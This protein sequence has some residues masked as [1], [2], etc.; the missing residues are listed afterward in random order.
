MSRQ[1]KDDPPRARHLSQTLAHDAVGFMR[2]VAHQRGQ[3]R[4][5]RTPE[6]MPGRCDADGYPHFIGTIHGFIN[7]FLALP[8]LRSLGN[9]I[10]LIDSNV[11]I[12]RRWKSLPYK[13]RIYLNGQNNDDGRAFLRYDADDFTGKKMR[14]KFKPHTDTFKLI[15]ATC[16]AS[17]EQGDFCYDELFVWA[18][19][20]IQ[21]RP[22][23]VADLRLR[24]PLVFNDEVQDN[25]E[26]HSSLL[27]QVFM[28]GGKPSVRQR[29]GDSNQAIYRSGNVTSG[30]TTDGFPGKGVLKIDLPNSFRFGPVIAG[31]ADP[32]GVT[33]Q[34][35]VGL[36]TKHRPPAILLFDDSSVQNVLPE[37][38]TYLIEVFSPALT[39][40]ACR[41]IDARSFVIRGHSFHSSALSRSRVRVCCACIAEDMNNRS[42]PE[43][44]RPFQRAAWL[45]RDIQTCP[46]HAQALTEITKFIGSAATHDFAAQVAPIL[47]QLS[48]RAEGVGSR[49][50]TPFET[51]ALARFHE[52]TQHSRNWLDQFSIDGAGKIC[53]VFGAMEAFGANVAISSLADDDR[54]HCQ[55]RGFDVTSGGEGDIRQLLSELHKRRGVL[56]RSVGP[57][58][59]FSRLYSWLAHETEDPQ[60]QP[61]RKIVADYCFDTIPGR[62]RVL[63]FTQSN[64]KVHSVHSAAHEYDLHPK[65]L[66]RLLLPTGVLH[67][68]SETLSNDHALFDAATGHVVIE[69]FLHSLTASKAAEYLNVQR[70][71]SDELLGGK[72]LPPLVRSR[73]GNAIHAVYE[74]SALDQFLEK[75][76]VDASPILDTDAELLNMVE[77]SKRACCGAVEIIDLLMERKL[78]TVRVSA[79]DQG[80]Q[81]IRVDLEEIRNHVRLADHGGLSLREVEDELGTSTAVVKALV[82]QGILQSR[83]AINPVNRCP[84]T[85]VDRESL[86]DFRSEF[87]SLVCLA[88]DRGIP[89]RR[90]KKQLSNIPAAFDRNEIG[91]TFFRRSSLP[92]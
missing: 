88:E 44:V 38:A 10:K 25:D 91:A 54:L 85:V 5:R 22:E 2:A 14:A 36:G 18:R 63:G 75:L 8:Y 33:P 69:R 50:P 59:H 61:L 24:I 86:A 51:Y 40:F 12:D 89:F 57:M 43:Y 81:A 39:R 58:T 83:T 79:A 66:Q 26:D 19:K 3:R 13:T 70:P 64:P 35:L 71:L 47:P 67:P 68:K 7:E 62:T 60:Y 42:A 56:K 92:D 48:Q 6:F 17:F 90:L 87:I 30:A 23:L 20:I 77:A 49:M 76:L 16:K 9:P 74:K 46:V 11:A 15:Q 32:F 55:R 28:E 80:I 52:D 34:G 78:Q 84:Q 82:T 65:L 1:R 4:D 29:F 45:I 27:S 37:Y 21:E 53:L 72:Y 31:L 73:P 41:R